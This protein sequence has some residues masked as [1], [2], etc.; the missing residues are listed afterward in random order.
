M[1]G[2][3]VSLISLLGFLVLAITAL[4]AHQLDARKVVVYALA[5]GAIFFAAAA[6]F[7]ALG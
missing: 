2:T 6:L 7:G 4:R 5:W 3:W 1:T